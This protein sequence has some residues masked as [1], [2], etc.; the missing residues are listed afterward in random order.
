MLG[1]SFRDTFDFCLRVLAGRSFGVR[2][3]MVHKLDR[4]YG[5]KY[6]TGRDVAGCGGF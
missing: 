4:V 3:C 6:A 2:T 5:A 1:F